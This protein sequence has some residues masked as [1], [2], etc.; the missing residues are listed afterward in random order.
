[1][2][3]NTPNADAAGQ[4]GQAAVNEWHRIVSQRDWDQLP[5]LLA[6]DVT[7]H[8]PARLEPFRGKETLVGILRLVFSIFEDFAYHRRFSGDD[9]YALEFSARLGDSQLTG[10]DLVRFDEAGKMTDLVVLLRPADA[11][12]KLGE[13]AA[14]RMAVVPD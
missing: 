13:E 7:Y 2:N 8:N 12:S 5:N 11:V 3:S 10:V 1:M 14:R 6:D 9:G 4:I